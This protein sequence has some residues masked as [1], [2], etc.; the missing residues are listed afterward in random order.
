M[1]SDVAAAAAT[2][3]EAL[4]GLPRVASSRLLGLRLCGFRP[5][6]PTKQSMEK[7]RVMGHCTAPVLVGNLQELPYP[8][9]GAASMRRASPSYRSRQDASWSSP[10]TLL[11]STPAPTPYAAGA[12]LAAHRSHLRRSCAAP[13]RDSARSSQ[14]P[15]LAAMGTRAC[16]CPLPPCLYVAQCHACAYVYVQANKCTSTCRQRS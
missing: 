4:A 12:A 13:A 5:R 10:R 3:G 1:V 16:Q 9:L 6:P 2:A 8:T 7:E 15:E 14:T 11:T